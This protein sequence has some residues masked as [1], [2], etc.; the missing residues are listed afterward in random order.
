MQKLTWLSAVMIGLLFVLP[1]CNEEDPVEEQALPLPEESM[2]TRP[3]ESG[4]VDGFEEDNG[5]HAWL[6]IP[7]AKAPVGELRWKAPVP[8]DPWEDTL[9]TVEISSKCTVDI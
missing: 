1:A 7:Y 5:S 9:E 2:T 3:T 8:A 6:G 4:R